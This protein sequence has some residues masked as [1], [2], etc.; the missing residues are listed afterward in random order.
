ME[1][2]PSSSSGMNAA[3]SPRSVDQVWLAEVKGAPEIRHGGLLDDPLFAARLAEAEN[4]V[5]AL[6]VTQMR[7]ASGAEEASPTPLRRS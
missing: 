1:H 4:E 2:T 3:A 5:L 7:V 6:E